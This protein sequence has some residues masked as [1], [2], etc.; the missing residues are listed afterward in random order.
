MTKTDPALEAIRKVRHQISRESGNDPAR[1]LEHYEE[2]QRRV[3]KSKIVRG[4]DDDDAGPSE[5][6]TAQPT[7]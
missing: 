3:G 4:P 1:L 6:D 7:P 2:L 5:S